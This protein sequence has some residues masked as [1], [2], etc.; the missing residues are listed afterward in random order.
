MVTVNKPNNS[1]D[2]VEELL[3]RLLTGLTPAAPVPAR[4]PEV[5]A[6]DK[7]LQLLEVEIQKRWPVPAIPAEPRGLEKMLRSYFAEQQ[8]SRQQPWTR[9]VWRG[10]IDMKCFSCGKSGHGANRWPTLDK[11]FPFMLPGWKAETTPT[12]FLI[13]SPRM[14]AD[15]RR[16][17]NDD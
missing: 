10:W 15:C 1:L 6:I 2:Q 12:G 8:P 7:L 9:P 5:P 17:E 11:S 14:T 16:A 4:A 3:K 13:V